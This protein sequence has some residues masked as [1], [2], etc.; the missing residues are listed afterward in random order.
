MVLLVAPV[1]EV[2]VSFG[3]IFINSEICG[4]HSYK[5]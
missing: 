3:Q 5:V 1:V 2:H 4:V